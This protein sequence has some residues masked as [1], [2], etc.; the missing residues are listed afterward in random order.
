MPSLRT[1][2]LSWGS[3]VCAAT[4]PGN[5]MM[6]ATAVRPSATASLRTIWSPWTRCPDATGNGATG[7]EWRIVDSVNDCFGDVTDYPPVLRA[8]QH[9]FR[10][11]P[12]AAADGK[13]LACLHHNHPVAVGFRPKLP[14]TLGIH[15]VRAVHSDK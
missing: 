9:P 3:G 12:P 6:R 13:N 15:D 5:A 2:C 8:E 4:R 10:G 11:I 7:G 1:S 14:D